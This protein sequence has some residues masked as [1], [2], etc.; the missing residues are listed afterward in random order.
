MRHAFTAFALVALAACATPGPPEDPAEVAIA[1]AVLDTGRPPEDIARDAARKPAQLIGFA[2]VKPGDFVAEML[3]G[4]GYFTRLLSTT[5][6]PGGRVIAL[7]P[8]ATVAAAPDQINPVRTIAANP[9]YANVTV[10]TPNGAMSPSIM[11]DV[12]WTSQNYHDIHAYYGAEA[13]ATTNRAV[14]AA[15]KPGGVYLI[16]DHVA[17]PGSGAT[18]ARTLHRID[19]DVIRREVA[20]AGFVL[21]AESDLLRNPADTHTASVFDPA[22]RGKTDQIVFRFR[23]PAA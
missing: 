20:A 14:F 6:G 11:V 23:K 17:A 15:L 12:V 5:V 1:A 7:V 8:A 4:S 21:E 16:I 18:Q 10:E 2:G 9:A 13:A 19:P 22:I 3:P